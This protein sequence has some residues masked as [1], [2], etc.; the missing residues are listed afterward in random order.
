MVKWLTGAIRTVAIY[1]LLIA[2]YATAAY[3]FIKLANDML[4]SWV[5][6]L[7]PVGQLIFS[8]FA[9]FLPPNMPYLLTGVLTYLLFSAAFHLTIEI[10]KLK[11][12]WAE[13]ALGSFKA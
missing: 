6:G 12:E 5:N 10:A 7:S 4:L 8:T 3:S 13:K 9:A 2:A 1:T 11:A